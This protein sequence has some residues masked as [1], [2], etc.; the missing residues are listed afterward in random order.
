MDGV[1]VSVMEWSSHS[2]LSRLYHILISLFN[3]LWWVW[4]QVEWKRNT[5]GVSKNSRHFVV[6]LCVVMLMLSV[7]E[8]SHFNP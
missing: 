3:L 5:I 1:E 8:F 2:T 7:S 6:P 4:F